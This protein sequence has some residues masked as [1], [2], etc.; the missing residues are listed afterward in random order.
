[1]RKQ[2]KNEKKILSIESKYNT[3]YPIN[4][5]QLEKFQIEWNNYKLTTNLLFSDP[6]FYSEL[7]FI[8]LDQS[9]NSDKYIY[10]DIIWSHEH[11]EFIEKTRLVEQDIKS[12]LSKSY[13]F[14]L[15]SQIQYKLA[16]KISKSINQ[17][18]ESDTILKEFYF[19]SN[20]QN[21]QELLVNKYY[22][23][24]YF[25]IIEIIILKMYQIEK[26]SNNK[27]NNIDLLLSDSNYLNNIF[28]LKKSLEK[29]LV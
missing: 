18:F 1:M 10:A 3:Y 22:L 4:K 14:G 26:N 23:E 29:S 15:I 7:K 9:L 24:Y 27:I 28:K 6:N 21:N 25:N 16:K 12:L 11:Y 8:E 19:N 5:N 2:K 17:I 13:K 20:N